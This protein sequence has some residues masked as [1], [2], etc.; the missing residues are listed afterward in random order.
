MHVPYIVC[1]Y[2]MCVCVCVSTMHKVLMWI[3][4]DSI[5]FLFRE[6]MARQ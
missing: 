2:V 5:H 1:L 6:K 4:V 3:V